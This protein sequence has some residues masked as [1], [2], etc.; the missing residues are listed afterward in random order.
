MTSVERKLERKSGYYLQ[1]ADTYIRACGKTY[2]AKQRTG[3]AVKK[4]SYISCSVRPV[5]VHLYVCQSYEG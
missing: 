3:G 4:H 1:R 2:H 5:V